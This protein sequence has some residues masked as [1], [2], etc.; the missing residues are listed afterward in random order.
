[1]S[2]YAYI[3]HTKIEGKSIVL[4]LVKQK[5]HIYPNNLGIWS[6]PATIHDTLSLYTLED[7]P[8][9]SCETILVIN[10]ENDTVHVCSFID[11]DS[12]KNNTYSYMATT[13]NYTYTYHLNERIELFNSES[14]L[15]FKLVRINSTFMRYILG[16]NSYEIYLTKEN[17]KYVFNIVPEGLRNKYLY[18]FL[19]M[20]IVQ[21]IIYIYLIINQIII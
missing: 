20:K 16:N 12:R 8:Y 6:S 3:V 17:E 4:T 19:R 13:G 11:V 2:S 18:S 15:Y 1:M 5:L 21:I 7:F 14:L 10:N 9:I